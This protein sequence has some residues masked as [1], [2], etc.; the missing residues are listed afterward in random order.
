METLCERSDACRQGKLQVVGEPGDAHADEPE[1]P[2]PVA[3]R[4]VER[5]GIVIADGWTAHATVDARNLLPTRVPDWLVA[6]I[7]DAE[8]SAG[9]PEEARSSS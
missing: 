9:R 7:A 5:D 1:R 6:A 2:G 3:E 8:I 4:A